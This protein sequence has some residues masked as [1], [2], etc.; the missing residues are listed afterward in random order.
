MGARSRERVLTTVLFTDIVGST[1]LA[2]EVGDKTWHELLA[3]HH[4]IVRNELKRFDGEW[5]LFDVV[6]VDGVAKH[7]VLD[8]R[9]AFARREAIQP[10][11][12]SGHRRVVAVGVGLAMAVVAVVA[13]F[14]SRSGDPRTVDR[15]VDTVLRID[16]ETGNLT[17]PRR[18]PS[19][20]MHSS[21]PICASPS[22]K[23][24][25]GS[26]TSWARAS[27]TWTAVPANS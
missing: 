8:P 13:F 15:P 12:L 10:R 21:R 2:T 26:T 7:P 22:A 19:G 18:A 6:T 25:S 3:R 11:L 24:G 17:G 4:A 20:S 5:E 1:E 14:V 9:E 16:A 23:E 27:S